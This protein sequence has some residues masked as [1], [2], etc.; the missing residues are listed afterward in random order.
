MRSIFNEI[1]FE[2]R[3]MGLVNS[4]HGSVSAVPKLLLRGNKNPKPNQR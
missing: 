3:H 2:K 1:F 4:A